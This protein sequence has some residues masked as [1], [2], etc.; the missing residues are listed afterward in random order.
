MYARLTR[1]SQDFGSVEAYTSLVHTVLY[2]QIL[3]SVAV[4]YSSIGFF[5]VST[6]E[7]PFP[8]LLFA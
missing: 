2:F 5:A 4:S 3:F 7:I 6:L 8:K 1:A